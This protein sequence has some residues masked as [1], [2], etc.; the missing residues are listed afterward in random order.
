MLSWRPWQRG[1]SW[2]TAGTRWELYW[3]FAGTFLM[4]ALALAAM[5]PSTRTNLV[6]QEVGHSE[7]GERKNGGHRNRA[8]L[9]RPP[10]E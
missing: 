9:E 10:L 5:V 4:A 7:T 2:T 8:G 1:R 6:P 3:L